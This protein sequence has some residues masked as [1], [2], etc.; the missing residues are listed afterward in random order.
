MNPKILKLRNERDKGK[1]KIAELQERVRDL[2]KQIKDLENIEIIGLVR[3]RGFT[4][5]QF[6][7]ILSGAQPPQETPPPEADNDAQT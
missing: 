5:E 4:L 6:A 1:A 3:E 2:E 7:S